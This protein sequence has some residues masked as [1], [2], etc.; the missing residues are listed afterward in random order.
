MRSKTIHDQQGGFEHQFSPEENIL[1]Q[2]FCITKEQAS[3]LES[4]FLRVYRV[5]TGSNHTP[6]CSGLIGAF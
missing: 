4:E 3:K 1:V 2:G 6:V 5:V